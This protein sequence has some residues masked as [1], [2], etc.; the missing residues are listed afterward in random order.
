[1]AEPM[2]SFFPLLFILILK[3]P[4]C[5]CSHLCLIWKDECSRCLLNHFPEDGWWRVGSEALVS[6]DRE[7]TCARLGALSGK[8]SESVCR[9]L[10]SESV[11]STNT[12]DVRANTQAITNQQGSFIYRC[13][14]YMYMEVC[15]IAFSRKH[16]NSNREI[17]KYLLRALRIPG[18]YVFLVGALGKGR[19]TQQ[20]EIAP[21]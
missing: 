2:E 8:C 14:L 18:W 4:E 21:C 1:M 20:V 15:P 6:T 13:G 16:L 3:T 17:M 11:S 5:I 12:S 9:T 7:F 19:A 10:L